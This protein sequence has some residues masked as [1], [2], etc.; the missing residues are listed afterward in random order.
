MVFLH[1][2]FLFL[3][4]C[5]KKQEVPD[6]SY[7]DIASATKELFIT[8]LSSSTNPTQF[9]AWSWNCNLP[10]CLYRHKINQDE[11]Y[12]FNEDDLY[13]TTKS[14]TISQG[15]GTYY[16][17]VEAIH[18]SINATLTASQT[19][20]IILDNTPPIL[21]EL[22]DDPVPVKSKMWT[23]RCLNG[24][25]CIYR[26]VINSSS[27]SYSFSASDIFDEIN[28]VNHNTGNGPQY[29]HIQAKD[30]A[31]NLS[32]VITAQA[33]FDNEPPI[34]TGLA[35]DST[36]TASKTWLWSCNESCTYRF[37]IDQTPT[38]TFTNEPFQTRISTSQ[39]NGNGMYYLHIQARDSLGNLSAIQHYSAILDNY[40]PQPIGL[41]VLSTPSTDITPDIT[42]TFPLGVNQ[43]DTVI[44]YSDDGCRTEMGQ[45][46]TSSNTSVVVTLSTP[47]DTD[48]TYNFYA[49]VRD[50]QG[51]ESDCSTAS[52]SYN[53]D[54]TPPILSGLTNTNTA[55]MTHSW[56]WGCNET[57]TYRYAINTMRAH[58]F[59]S[60]PFASTTTIT[61]S[62]G[63]NTYYLHIQAQDAIGNTTRTQRYSAVLDNTAP[64]L[65]S[66]YITTPSN[67][68]TPDI[69]VNF[70]GNDDGDETVFL[71][72]DNT[73]STL[74]ESMASSDSNSVTITLSTPLTA[75]G[76]YNYYAK[77]RDTAGNES[78]CS[79]SSVSYEFDQTPPQLNGLSNDLRL[80]LS[81]TWTWS[82]NENCTYRYA[83][84]AN[85]THT[86]TTEIFSSDLTATLPRGDGTYYLHIQAR[87]DAGNTTMTEHYSVS[88]DNTGPTTTGLSNDPIL[89]QSKTWTWGCNETCTYRYTI[90]TS[91]LHTFTT[92]SFTA[93][94][95]ATQSTGNGTYYLHIQ[96]QDGL[97]N[98]G[99]IE[100]YSV[101][102]DNTAPE[103]TGLSMTS[104]LSHDTTPDITV[105][106]SGGAI[107]DSITIYSD[108]TCTTLVGQTISTTANRAV[109]TLS[110][111]INT[112]GTYTYYANITDSAGNQ[113][114][115]SSSSVSYELDR[116]APTLIGLADDTDL[117]SEKTWT[118]DCSETC[119]YRYIIN[120]S[121]SHTF[122]TESFNSIRTTTHST[123]NGTHYLH[124]QARDNAGNIGSAQHY[125]FTMETIPPNIL[126]LSNDTTATQS[127]TW[128]WNCDETCTY[129]YIINTDANYTFTTETFDSTTVATQDT[130][131]GIYFLHIQARDSVGNLSSIEH[132]SVPLDNTAPTPTLLSTRSPSND[133]TPNITI[134]ILGGS[135]GDTATLYSDNTCNTQVGTQTLTLSSSVTITVTTPLDTDGT[136]NYYAK[137]SDSLNNESSCSA[138]FAS[139]VLDR[140]APTLSGLANDSTTTTSK[141]WAW[142]CNETCTYRYVI[143]MNSSYTFTAEPFISMSTVT[144]NTGDG[145]YYLHIQARDNA[146]NIG[147]P[148]HYTFSMDTASP[149]PTS[150]TG[151]T[152]SDNTTPDV[153]INFSGGALG[154][155][156]LLYSDS[157]CS[158]QVGSNT[159]STATSATVSL[160]T[161]LSSDG[162]YTFYAKM[163]DSLGNESDCSTMHL[164]YELDR[165]APILQ[166]LANEPSITNSKT[167]TWSC[168]DNCT[169]RYVINT[170]P[171]HVFSSEI[172]GTTTT[173]THTTGDGSYYLHIQATDDAGNIG[174]TSHYSFVMDTTPPASP[175][176]LNI[177]D[178]NDVDSTPAVT[179]GGVTAGD[180]AM[181]YTDNGCTNAAGS[182][183]VPPGSTTVTINATELTDRATSSTRTYSY[184]Y[185]A[186]SQDPATNTSPCSTASQAYTFIAP[187]S[188]GEWV[189]ISEATG[190]T[191][192]VGYNFYVMK[193]EAKAWKDDN[194]NNALEI[195][196]VYEGNYFNYVVN[197]T[198]FRWYQGNGIST[199]E[200]RPVSIPQKYPWRNINADDSSSEC[201]SLGSRYDL[202]SNGEWMAIARDIEG[203]G[204]NW[205]TGTVGS[206]C[207]KRG[208]STHANLC[209]SDPHSGGPSVSLHPRRGLNRNS[210]SILTLSSGDQIFDFSSNVAE[211]VDWDSTISGLQKG[212]DCRGDTTELKDYTCIDLTSNA[213]YRPSVITYTSVSQGV[214]LWETEAAPG[215]ALLRGGH[216]NVYQNNI[217]HSEYK[218]GLYHINNIYTQDISANFGTNSDANVG[219]YVGFRCVYRP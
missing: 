78:V 44:V 144:H 41:S 161:P 140:V 23:W 86:F 126:G 60:E 74:I 112:D 184:T 54:T 57:C 172:F 102:L 49:K 106:F 77:V 18:Q 200:Y 192:N 174:T 71:Y 133:T 166:G 84:N 195:N 197:E 186:K 34:L 165:A 127:K 152:P 15:D 139:Y 218:V 25:I 30:T 33:T 103:I 213:Q 164:A 191:A 97:N 109:V 101:F 145:L 124:I 43:G 90:N 6:N 46:V 205:S 100:H 207:L 21:E 32:S 212:P 162:I 55:S 157:T 83:I 117:T 39:D 171:H 143:N 10:A 136:Y 181:L 114:L 2:L 1:L 158:V 121:A 53:L 190:G 173:V 137:V 72:S 146:G 148:Q 199:A 178:S 113:S 185:Y 107:G 219:L 11:Y 155:T 5:G 188:L 12:T 4:S 208:G 130:G 42:V 214:G 94:T 156:A 45:A 13:S 196:E 96:S 87:D 73:C 50:P 160:D 104:T 125:S 170:T 138:H 16:L 9:H 85:A 119:T 88:L 201:S 135:I 128:M 22:R 80:A 76:T 189:G 51:N 29:I 7:Y 38:H 28:Y 141:E 215:R 61:Q 198:P 151:Q 64:I 98:I 37:T 47:L 147:L 20:Y 56:T 134:G 167:W 3:L 65:T 48:G 40:A 58:I 17:H 129:R 122:T 68:T 204:A 159:A 123:G 176:S 108:N 209:G 194:N 59:T 67:D 91:P 62:G 70:S 202:I 149:T 168:D 105:T 193:Y 179:V 216:W 203:V 132:Y 118:W 115:C 52:V 89:K 95:T 150:I 131:T 110:S 120:T 206:G 210:N 182:G 82:C 63:D 35:Q 79:T 169:Y 116:V 26:Y 92:E 153:T 27:E 217:A 154:D 183:V 111:P 14:A 31:G 75:D 177:T 180:T 81:K 66:F 24:E 99:S 36:P 175:T 187:P 8:G 142:S 211:W 69:T 19:V 163:R 93:V